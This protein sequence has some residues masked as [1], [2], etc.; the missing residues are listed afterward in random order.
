[1]TMYNSGLR[2][3]L[4]AAFLFLGAPASLT[5]ATI[6]GVVRFHGDIPE[7]GTVRMVGDS[8]CTACHT[9]PPPKQDLLV[10]ASGEVQNVVVYIKD[11][12]PPATVNSPPSTPVELRQEGCIFYPRVFGIRTGQELRITNRDNTMLNMVAA[13]KSNSRFIKFIKNSSGAPE[14]AKFE[15]PE[16]PVLL[17]SD[18]HPW[19]ASYAGVFNHPYF[20]VTDGQGRFELRDVPTGMYTLSTWHEKLGVREVRLQVADMET[21]TVQ[22]RYGS[23]PVEDQ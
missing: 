13:P 6:S 3:G 7:T 21:T 16:V 19:M 12:L 23:R 22:F 17:K 14:T 5:A 10:N 18:V 8:F 9:S 2:C 20:A 15:K 1:M 11:G 4:L